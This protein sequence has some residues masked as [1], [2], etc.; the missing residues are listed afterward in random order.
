MESAQET[1]TMVGL[2]RWD[3]L[4]LGI[5]VLIAVG[6][7]LKLMSARRDQLVSEVQEQID[8]RKKK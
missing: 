3:L 8:A 5:A 1:L 4:L 2:D 6:S 7:L